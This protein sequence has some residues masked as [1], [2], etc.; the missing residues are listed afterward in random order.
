MQ[1]LFYQERAGHSIKQDHCVGQAKNY[2]P[3]SKVRCFNHFTIRIQNTFYTE[4]LLLFLRLAAYD[5]LDYK[6][7]ET[8]NAEED[9]VGGPAPGCLEKATK[10][11]RYYGT[12]GPNDRKQTGI[13][14]Q[15]IAAI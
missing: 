5:H 15:L 3:G 2:H 6:K 10:E 8:E 9:K 13:L 4:R 12:N 14:F 11:R 1:F 7:R